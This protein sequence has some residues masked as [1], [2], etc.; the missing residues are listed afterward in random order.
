MADDARLGQHTG[1]PLARLLGVR[2]GQ[3]VV[4]G[5]RLVVGQQQP[6]VVD[7]VVQ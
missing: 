1:G 5:V 7:R 6:G 4:V 2:G 3:A